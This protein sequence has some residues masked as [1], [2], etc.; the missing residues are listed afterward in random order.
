M[1]QVHALPV[2]SNRPSLYCLMSPSLSSLSILLLAC[3]AYMCCTPCLSTIFCLLILLVLSPRPSLYCLL[4]PPLS[5]PSVLLLAYVARPQR[6]PVCLLFAVA[7]AFL[8]V[9]P[10]AFMYCPSLATA[11][12]SRKIM[13]CPSLSVAMAGAGSGKDTDEPWHRD[14]KDCTK[15]IGGQARKRSLL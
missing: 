6:P 4:S 9:G 5:S 8:S 15:R 12:L 10:V 11:R 3:V 13:R 2:L 7:A 1:C 14:K